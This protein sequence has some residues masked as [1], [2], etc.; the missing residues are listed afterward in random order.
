[1]RRRRPPA[2][3]VLH[4][5]FYVCDDVV[6]VLYFIYV[7]VFIGTSF[8]FLFVTCFFYVCDDAVS[9]STCFFYVCDDVVSVFIL[10]FI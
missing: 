4:C 7:S 2:K 8:M 9:V 1:M 6:S 3:R 10:I 5:L